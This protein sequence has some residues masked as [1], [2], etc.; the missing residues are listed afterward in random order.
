MGEDLWSTENRQISGRPQTHRNKIPSNTVPRTAH[1][2][3]SVTQMRRRATSY[4]ASCTSCY[5]RASASSSGSALPR[6][7]KVRRRQCAGRLL[8]MARTY[9]A[10]LQ[11]VTNWFSGRQQPTAEQILIVQEFLEKAGRVS[12]TE[13]SRLS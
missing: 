9:E 5:F 10:N 11:A 6:F 8:E 4:L 1:A 2:I 12:K 3:P 13:T 7:T